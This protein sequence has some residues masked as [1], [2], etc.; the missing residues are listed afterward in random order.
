MSDNYLFECSYIKL[1]L[2]RQNIS[3]FIL[4]WDH[5]CIR[6]RSCI[7]LKISLWITIVQLCICISAQLICWYIHLFLVFVSLLECE[8]TP[9]LFVLQ[10]HLR[11][12]LMRRIKN[13]LFRYTVCIYV[14]TCICCVNDWMFVFVVLEVVARLHFCYT[15]YNENKDFQVQF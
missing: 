15:W 8:W 11:K 7:I 13:R 5:V 14:C 2:Q 4:D 9:A 6:W 10:F 12:G 3:L 1:F